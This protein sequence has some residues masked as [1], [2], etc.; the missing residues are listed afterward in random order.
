MKNVKFLM[1]MLLAVLSLSSCEKEE[2]EEILPDVTKE[3]N[4]FPNECNQL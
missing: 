2:E 1:L 4:E 3:E